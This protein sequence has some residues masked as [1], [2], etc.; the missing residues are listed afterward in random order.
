M[1]MS[2]CVFAK[3]HNC[4]ILTHECCFQ[5]IPMKDLKMTDRNEIMELAVVM[6]A[7]RCPHIVGF[8]GCLQRDVSII[9]QPNYSISAGCVCCNVS[10]VCV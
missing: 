2:M 1:A 8:Y 9:L 10:C 7:N 6:Q 5:K 3:Y 4:S